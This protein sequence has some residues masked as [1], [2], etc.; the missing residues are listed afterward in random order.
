MAFKLHIVNQ[1]YFQQ[2]GPAALWEG[3]DNG[4]YLKVVAFR[5]MWFW[6]YHHTSLSSALNLTGLLLLLLG[7]YSSIPRTF[8]SFLLDCE[9]GG[10]EAVDD[11][12][13]NHWKPHGTF[14][15]EPNPM[16]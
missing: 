1:H 14:C 7:I 8:L 5:F 9:S 16:P 12:S 13:F 2:S 10:A 11:G 3:H 4:T 6:L 15:P